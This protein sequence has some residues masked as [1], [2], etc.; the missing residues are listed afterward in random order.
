MLGTAHV[1]SVDCTG[2]AQEHC[3]PPSPGYMI[4]QCWLACHGMRFVSFK[5]SKQFHCRAGFVMS[6][7]GI[8]LVISGGV[9][10]APICCCACLRVYR[11]GKQ[12]WL[13]YRAL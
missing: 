9:E 12:T 2:M 8:C 1:T 5:T 4:L 11:V 6:S 3:R 13:L 10:S 7:L